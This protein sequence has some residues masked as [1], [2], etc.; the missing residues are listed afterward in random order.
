MVKR[1][2][3]KYYVIFIVTATICILSGLIIYKNYKERKFEETKEKYVDNPMLQYENGKVVEFGDLLE[4]C[5]WEEEDVD[6]IVFG[7]DE[8]RDRFD[9][10][11][12]DDKEI[13]EEIMEYLKDIS[14]IGAED[15]IRELD[16]KRNWHIQLVDKSSEFCIDYSGRKVENNATGIIAIG[17]RFSHF[18]GSKKDT[19][20]DFYPLVSDY[21]I[22]YDNEILDKLKD[23]KEEYVKDITVDEIR[24]IKKNNST[25][26]ADYFKRTHVHNGGKEVYNEEEKS[27]DNVVLYK[28]PIEDSESFMEVGRYNQNAGGMENPNTKVHICEVYIVNPEGEKIDL[29]E[30]TDEEFEQ[31][32][33]QEK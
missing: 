16:D 27:E 5:E 6:I 7:F 8:G 18:S 31:F 9:L 12:V 25:E 33:S 3:I 13:I 15:N 23:L 20:P 4:Y 19:F 28:F 30:C 21:I 1:M 11:Y 32:I 10:Y 14:Y 2:N 24:Q 22:D 26:Y 29:F 17:T